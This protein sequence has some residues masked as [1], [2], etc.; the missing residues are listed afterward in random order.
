MTLSEM[1]QTQNDKYS[2]SPPIWN[3]KIGN[4][5]KQKWI[6]G[7]QGL[8]KGS[9]RNY[10]LLGFKFLLGWYK[11]LEMR[12]W[13]WLYNTVNITNTIK[14]YNPKI[15][16]IGKFYVILYHNEHSNKN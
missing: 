10:W 1:S 12:Q 2:K 9:M 4:L 16:H 8:G 7:Y 11:F 15:S 14:L 5:Q 6:R 13:W 3:T